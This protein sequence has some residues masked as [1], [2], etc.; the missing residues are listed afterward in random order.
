MT[1]R[2]GPSL[3]A[4]VNFAFGPDRHPQTLL[5]PLVYLG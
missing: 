5:P 1:V 3:A 4:N 2:R